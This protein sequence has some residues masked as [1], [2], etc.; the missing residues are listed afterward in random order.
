MINDG[1]THLIGDRGGSAPLGQGSLSG[2][3]K[4]DASVTI[5]SGS[6]GVNASAMWGRWYA[7]SARGE[8]EPE[9]EAK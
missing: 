6:N 4:C 9:S 3:A 8:Q 2:A 7:P 1:G 5:T